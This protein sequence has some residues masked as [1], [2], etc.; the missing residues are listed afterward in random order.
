LDD[1]DDG[2]G[3]GVDPEVPTGGQGLVQRAGAQ[4]HALGRDLAGSGQRVHALTAASTGARRFLGA[5]EAAPGRSVDLVTYHGDPRSDP[6]VL[7][8]P[9]AV[10]ARGSGS[11]DATGGNAPPSSTIMV[12]G[13]D[14]A[15]CRVRPIPEPSGPDP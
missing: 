4:L 8:R 6:A 14:G 15:S 5:P 11:A 9:T 13:A 7:F 2:P 12:A 1:L 3:S 10:F